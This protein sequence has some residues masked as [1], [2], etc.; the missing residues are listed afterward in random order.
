M[1][2]SEIL[3]SLCREDAGWSAEVTADWMQGH[4]AFGGLQAAFALRA[5]RSLVP[6]GL[7]V[8]ALQVCFI[9]PVPAGRVTV[10]ARL[11]RTGKNV[12][13]AEAQLVDGNEVLCTVLGV[14]GAPRPSTVS[15]RP[16]QPPVAD[17]RSPLFPYVPGIT[18]EFTRH[19]T[20]RWLRGSIPFTGSADTEVVV[21][22]GMRDGGLA[23][24][25]HV[26]ALADFIPP[27]ALSMLKKP[28]PGSSLTWMMEFLG[29]HEQLPLEGWRVDA[30]LLAARDGYSNQSVMLWGP[31]GEPVALSRQSMVVF[32]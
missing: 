5:M 3:Q 13:H 11:L 26:V 8:R 15:V 24:S 7:P 12:V 14:F 9:A 27:V 1:Q 22:L 19:F 21:Q 31:G 17:D 23:T 25:E 2:F 6:E 16:A 30:T 20:A 28:A 29:A 18:P 32:G 10:R 4:S